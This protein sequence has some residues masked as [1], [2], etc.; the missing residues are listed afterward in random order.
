MCDIILQFDIIMQFGQIF[1]FPC[2]LKQ[3]SGQDF[4][5]EGKL[6]KPGPTLR[7][8]ATV[9]CACRLIYAVTKEEK[10]LFFTRPFYAYNCINIYLAKYLLDLNSMANVA[11]ANR[12][13]NFA[14]EQTIVRHSV[15][16][17]ARL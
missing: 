4:V 1:P 14:T 12:S 6:A 9:T 7:R 2:Q 17:V 11:L 3:S 5:N 13:R 15:I 8:Y 10:R 16:P